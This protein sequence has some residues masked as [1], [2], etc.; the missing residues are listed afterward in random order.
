VIPSPKSQ[1]TYS[2]KIEITSPLGCYTSAEFP[3][4]ITIEE[5]PEADF[6]YT[7]D[8]LTNFDKTVSFF[9]R[10]TGASSWQWNFD[11]EAVLFQK[12]PV[13]TFQDTGVHRIELIVTHS[14]GCPDT[15]VKIIDIVPISTFHVPNAFS[16]NDDGKNDDFKGKGFVE[17][18][19]NFSMTIW[20]RWGE[21][22]FE[23]NNPEEGWNGRKLNT[24][25]DSPIGVYVYQIQYT[26]PRGE[27]KTLK[28]YATL[29]R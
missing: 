21:L 23:T 2:I 24:G 28:G 3:N 25:D 6:I 27:V 4:W 9:D 7:P 15:I 8:M 19:N 17:G 22:V 11:E 10:S 16:P 20:N 29:V 14:S 18:L 13:Y 5:S 12:D 1:M 26:A